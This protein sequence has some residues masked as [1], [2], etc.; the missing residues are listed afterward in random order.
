MCNIK[1]PAHIA[2]IVDGTI[3]TQKFK[4]VVKFPDIIALIIWYGIPIVGF[5]DV[6]SVILNMINS[7][8]F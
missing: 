5:N 2:P 4:A 6:Q 8:T 3:S 7:I 1:Y